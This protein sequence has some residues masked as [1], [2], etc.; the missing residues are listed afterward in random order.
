ME[1]TVQSYIALPSL[2]IDT[3][4]QTSQNK[5]HDSLLSVYN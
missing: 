1:A 3:L 4:N 5:L 2:F